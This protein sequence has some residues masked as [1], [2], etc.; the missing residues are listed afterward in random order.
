MMF[1]LTHWSSNK[2]AAPVNFETCKSEMEFVFGK[3]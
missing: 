1:N 2:I 3:K